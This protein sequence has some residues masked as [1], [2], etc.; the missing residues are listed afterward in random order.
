MKKYIHVPWSRDQ[1]PI[2]ANFYKILAYFVTGNVK[3]SLE[4]KLD[5]FS[6]RSLL[7]KKY[8]IT[9]KNVTCFKRVLCLPFIARIIRFL[10][11]PELKAQVRYW[12]SVRPVVRPSVGPSACN[13]FT[14]STSSPEPPRQFQ[15]NLAHSILGWR[16][17]NFI[18]RK[19]ILFQG[20]KITKWQN[21]I[22]EI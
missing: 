10:T 12:S 13:R 8:F 6:L 19:R 2:E 3:G 22:V 15:P 4:R 21:Y 14:F 9:R 5:A 11:S 20:E 17:F 18:Q 16:G 7:I 1:K